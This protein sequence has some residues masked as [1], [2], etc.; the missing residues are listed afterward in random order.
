MCVVLSTF[1]D[2]V[3]YPGTCRPCMWIPNSVEH[4]SSWRT[5]SPLLKPNEMHIYA[6]STSYLLVIHLLIKCASTRVLWM[7]FIL[8]VHLPPTLNFFLHLLATRAV[9]ILLQKRNNQNAR[10]QI[11][12]KT[13]AGFEVIS[14]NKIY[15]HENENNHWPSCLGNFRK[16]VPKETFKSG[17]WAWR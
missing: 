15:S 1:G 8:L 7:H 17:I 14:S 11:Y 6:A 12:R 10:M 4:K 13:N 16:L 5:T 3:M 2:A 9:P